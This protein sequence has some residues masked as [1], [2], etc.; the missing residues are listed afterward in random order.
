VL[1]DADGAAQRINFAQSFNGLA[2]MLAPLLGG[3]FILSGQRLTAAQEGAMSPAQLAQYLNHEA[4]AV[5]VPYLLIGGIVLLVAL[6]LL[7]TPLPELEEEE[8]TSATG[9]SL[10]HEK[11]L[12]MGV[13][14]QFFYVGAQVCV[15]CFFIRFAERV[16][17]I[18]EKTAALYLSGA[19]LGFTAGRF[20]GTALMQ[21]VRRPARLLAL[22]SL[23]NFFL[24][25]LAVLLPGKP[26]VYALMGVE[27]FMSIM[28]PT[29][30][31]LSIQG[32]GAK[33]E[34]ESSLIIMAIVGGAI[35]PV[36]AGRVSDASSIQ[37]AY[38]VPALCFLVVLFFALQ[39]LKVT[40]VKLVA[41]H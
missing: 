2:T 23:I 5:Q 41:A 14:K 18:E 9:G 24:V 22:Y 11:N 34:E 19:L 21:Y 26:S 27:F 29:I 25:L 16:A 30:F 28:F 32:L 33:T 15:S 35:F 20:I 8:E 3:V 31:S 13:V 10:L 4:Q 6:A 40:S 7:R 36:I 17:G 38:V 12:L 39:N 1:G 37:V